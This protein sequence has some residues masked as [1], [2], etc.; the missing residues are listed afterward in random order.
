VTKPISWRRQQLL[1]LARLLQDNVELFA[2]ALRLD[3]G[4]PKQ[5]VYL[6]EVGASIQ[7]CLLNAENLSEWTK[8]H[9]V[10]VADYQKSWKARYHHSP[11]GVVLIIVCVNLKVLAP[12]FLTFIRRPWNYP[13]ILSVQ[14]LSSAIAAGCCALMKPSELSP[15]FSTLFAE[16]LPK[17]LDPAAYSVVQGAI[18]ETTKVLELKCDSFICFF[19]IFAF[20]V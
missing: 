14:P 1:Q 4:R 3:L 18:P 10:E 2:E 9:E 5:E 6:I 11:K 20:C 17:Y 16:L 12:H 7:R 13:V 8:E 15:H 19:P